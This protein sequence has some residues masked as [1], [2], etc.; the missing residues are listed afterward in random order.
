VVPRAADKLK[1]LVA[2]EVVLDRYLWG[3]VERI[4]PKRRFQCSRSI[5]AK[6]ARATPLSCAP[7]WLH[8]VPRLLSS[9]RLAQTA[10][11][12]SCGRCWSGWVSQPAPESNT[13]DALR[14]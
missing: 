2:G 3:A 13:R 14:S 11:A 1:I 10:M 9:A 8:L 5:V 7:T 6:N 12:V 4:R